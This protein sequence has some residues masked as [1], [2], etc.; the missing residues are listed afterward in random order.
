MPIRPLVATLALLA[1]LQ[2]AFAADPLPRAKP[3][4]VGLSS[5]R[6]A[7]IT[8]VLRADVEQGRIPGAVVAVA[9]KGKLA[10]FE[11]IGFR[12]KAANVA[13]STD[14][15]FTIASMTK[16]FVSV[17]TMMLYEEGRVLVNDPV[18]NYLPV[19]ANMQVAVLDG[20]GENIVRTVPP[21]RPVTVQDLL[22][23]TSGITYGGRGTTAVH[24]LYPAS[25]SYSGT[26]LTSAGFLE[27]IAKAPLL[28]QPG[29]VWDYSLSVDVLGLVLEASEKKTLGEILSERI[30]KPLKMSDTY[31]TVPPEKASRYARALP[32]DPDTG[33][34]QN[35]LDLTKPLKFECGGGCGASTAGDYLRFAQMLL[36]RGKLD[37]QRLL[38]RKTVEYMTSDHLGPEV[39]NNIAK[40]DANRTGYGFGLGFA[41][42]KAAG[43][44]GLEGS[45]GDYSW[46]GA[47][48]TNFWVDPREELVVV[49]MAAAPGAIRVHYRQ[50]MSA[51]VYQ[52]LID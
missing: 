24:K 7:R 29:T 44:S 25:S 50:L 23:H 20:S 30:F 1:A 41:V 12:D 42:R 33:K 9:R 47:N 18:A 22:R 13:M 46:G 32:N 27:Q 45:A 10:Y 8:S 48:G 51:L 14:T 39:Q 16:P 40:V 19:L 11:A 4:S 21:N 35:L 34:P 49:F 5:Q 28:Y 36:D 6:L 26:N 38:S 37:D 2:P 43:V 15:I 31:F 3:E 17:G 52:A